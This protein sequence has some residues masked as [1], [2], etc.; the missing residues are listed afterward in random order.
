MIR[1]GIIF[2]T[3]CLLIG[4]VGSPRAVAR[5]ELT[6]GVTQFPATFNPI[7]NA[8]L[9][10]SYVLAMALRP[11]TAYD[12]SW[13][14]VCFLCT[15]LPTVDN[16]LAQVE[17]LPDG[18]EGMAVS[19]AI[20]PGATWGDGTPVTSRDAMF[21]WEVGRHPL[22]GVADHQAYARIRDI[23]VHDDKNFTVHL[24]QRYYDYNIRAAIPLLPS[25]IESE[26]FADPREYRFR[27]TYDTD[28]TNPGLY[29]GPYRISEVEPGSHIVLERNPTWWGEPAFF[30]R[31][32]V[33]VIENTV[34]LEANLL[35]G[36]I[37]YVAGELGFSL[38]QAL[39]F[40]RRHPDQFAVHYQ[41]GL[42]YEHIDFNLD[43]PIVQDKQV[44]QA[45]LYALDRELLVTQLFAGHQ[46]VAHSNVNPLDRVYAPDTKTYPYDPDRAAALLDAAGWSREGKG[47]RE[48][49]RGERLSV[50][51]MTT[52]GD[53]VRE[54]VQQVLQSQWN[55]VGID[56]TI[57]NEPARVFFGQTMA[58]R[59]FPALGM[60]AWL[61]APESV[62]RST[63][64]SESIPTAENN[65]SGQNS[66]GFVN[67]EMDTL[68]D[69]AEIELDR[70]A[71]KAL[72][73]RMQEI[74]AEELPVLPLYF[75]AQP[76]VLPKWLRGI[77]PT[78][79]LESTTLWVEHWRAAE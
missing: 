36:A 17:E 47:T 5:D 6:I 35:S 54:L 43:N 50:R 9:A 24:D 71:R 19:Y 3:I 4:A 20:Q 25:H 27:T 49:E 68:I 16:G 76:Y 38:D 65:W 59:V 23:E 46:P 7:I 37:D 26:A 13:E 44:R 15:E 39:S 34:A 30:R 75:R 70:N 2:L 21:G 14:P 29:F 73:R 41:P 56:V 10:K 72:W 62:P 42:F 45:M 64:H 22:T 51:L 61:S 40:E 11:L 1:P 31:I 66:P 48:N 63:L 58:H 57:K 18:G 53:K 32:V 55:A 67:A 78:G 52:A 12:A 69:R 33:R 28:T 79:H 77:K 8:M 60:Y 74:Y